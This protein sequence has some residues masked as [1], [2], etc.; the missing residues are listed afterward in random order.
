MKPHPCFHGWRHFASEARHCGTIWPPA[1]THG[2]TTYQTKYTLHLSQ[3]DRSV[4]GSSSSSSSGCWVQGKK[5]R[6]AAPRG[7]RIVGWLAGKLHRRREPKKKGSYLVS[8]PLSLSPGPP[9]LML[10]CM[11]L[12]AAGGWVECCSATSQGPEEGAAAAVAALNSISIHSMWP[13]RLFGSFPWTGGVAW[14]GPWLCESQGG[15]NS[16]ALPS[17]DGVPEPQDGLK[18]CDRSSGY[19]YGLYLVNLAVAVVSKSCS[20]RGGSGLSLLGFCSPMPRAPSEAVSGLLTS[21]GTSP[22]I[23]VVAP[24]LVAKPLVTSSRKCV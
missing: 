21:R 13:F 3:S 6:G 1:H 4:L 20:R 15:S 2:H 9:C 18:G 22:L 8:R 19:E 5:T 11:S 14:H 10:S 7:A 24:L 16:Q 17:W 12:Y 23:V